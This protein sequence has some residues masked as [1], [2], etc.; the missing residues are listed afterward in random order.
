MGQGMG[1]LPRSWPNGGGG[2]RD[3]GFSRGM[4]RGKVGYWAFNNGE[5][6]KEKKTR[7]RIDDF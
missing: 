6:Q 7:L 1:S 2:L 3:Y 4:I 5:A